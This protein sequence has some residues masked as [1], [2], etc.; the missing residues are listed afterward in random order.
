MVARL[1]RASNCLQISTWR[2]H[3]GINQISL[4]RCPVIKPG[5]NDR[6]GC[7][8]NKKT[9]PQ[10]PPATASIRWNRYLI[11]GRNPASVGGMVRKIHAGICTPDTRRSQ[12]VGWM[13]ADAP[14]TLIR[15]WPCRNRVPS[16]MARRP[17]KQRSAGADLFTTQQAWR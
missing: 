17:P 11:T 5:N 4:R 6:F 3:E 16:Q 14:I 15:A 10:H 8:S 9:T 1:P 2:N 13:N 12:P 7:A